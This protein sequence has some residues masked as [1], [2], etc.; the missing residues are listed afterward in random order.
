[1]VLPY[2]KG[3]I[4]INK[5]FH[6][7]LVYL[8]WSFCIQSL[9]LN[10]FFINASLMKKRKSFL[11]ISILEHVVVICLGWKQSKIFYEQVTFG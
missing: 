2:P 10:T 6:I 1:M 11:T 3:L 9:V 5:I 7:V 8:L 4:V